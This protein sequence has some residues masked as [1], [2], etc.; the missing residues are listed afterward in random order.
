[1]REERNGVHTDNKGV[2]VYIYN[3]MYGGGWRVCAGDGC[4]MEGGGVC[5]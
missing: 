1:M 3:V 5:R 4:M 2:N